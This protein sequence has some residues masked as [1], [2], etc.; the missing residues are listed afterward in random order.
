VGDRFPRGRHDLVDHGFGFY[1]P[2]AG[3]AIAS[4]HA[5]TRERVV[6]YPSPS[7]EGLPEGGDEVSRGRRRQPAERATTM[8]SRFSRSG[9]QPGSRRSFSMTE[10]TR[11]V[12][13]NGRPSTDSTS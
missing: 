13:A 3:I 4:V 8:N 7:G 9:E 11:G 10:A 6:S 2:V 1:F 5:A 12:G